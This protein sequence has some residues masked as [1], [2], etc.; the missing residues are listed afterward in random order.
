MNK[1]VKELGCTGSHFV[2]TNGLHDDDHYVTA[3]D[4]AKI[5]KQHLKMKHSV[6]LHA[7]LIIIL[8]QRTKINMEKSF[9]I[10]IRW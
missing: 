8:H 2:T 1:K 10:I 4:M 7:N 6:M 3:R 5:Q 9:G